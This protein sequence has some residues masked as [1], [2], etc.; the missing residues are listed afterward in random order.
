M[1]LCKGCGRPME[2]GVTEDG[3]KIPLDPKPIIY[4]IS[5]AERVDGMVRVIKLT[6]GEAMVSHFSTCPK[7]NSF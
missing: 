5:S 6:K 1:T 7:A 3:K 2:W 4:A